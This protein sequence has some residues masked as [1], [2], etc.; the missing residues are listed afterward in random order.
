MY[1]GGC[2]RVNGRLA[3]SRAIGDYGLK[4]IVV[5]EPDVNSI[6]LNGNEDFFVMACD[7]L[8]DFAEE[9]KVASLIYEKLTENNGESGFF[10]ELMNGIIYSG[11]K[12][13]V[14][15]SYVQISMIEVENVIK[16]VLAILFR[17]VSNSLYVC[18]VYKWYNYL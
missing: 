9:D 5:G 2:A 17:S 14:K 1:M 15:Y 4:D 3:V 10:I 18:D 6:S 7:G 12:A 8:W 13:G 11:T 16:Y